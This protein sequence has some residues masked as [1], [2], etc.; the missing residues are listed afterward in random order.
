MR[1]LAGTCSR[2][3]LDAVPHEHHRIECGTAAIGRHGCVSGNA[4]EGES[5]GCDRERAAVSHLVAIRRVPVQ[6]DVHVLKEAGTYH[7]DLTR[8]ALFGRS[9]VVTQSAGD[10]MF[11]HEVL[12][13]DDGQSRTRAEKVV[14]TA[15]TG[16]TGDDRL[17]GRNGL[18]RET[19]ERI[20]LPED[21]NDWFSRAIRGDEPSRFVGDAGLNRE[22]GFFELVLQQRRAL[23][24]VVT[25]LG[26]APNLPRDAL[27]RRG[28]GIDQGNDLDAVGGRRFA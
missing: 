21:G 15:V 22:S 4:V 12:D 6:D 26:E 2:E 3:K 24:L 7:V 28:I 18:L 23:T 25:E 14:A 1:V 13:R 8:P 20:E 9:A 5:G 16:G 11:R 27:V 10:V 19:R 17:A